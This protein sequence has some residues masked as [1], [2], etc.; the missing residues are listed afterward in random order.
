MASPIA[1]SLAGLSIYW[2]AN[3]QSP[4]RSVG[5]I[6]RKTI[7]GAAGAVILA[8]LSDFDLIAGWIVRKYLHHQF[9][10]TLAFAVLAGAICALASPLFKASAR[11][12]FWLA[13]ALVAS[14]V[15]IDYFTKDTTTPKG[16]MVFWPITSRYFISP[17]SVFLDIWRMSPALAFG[18]NNFNA[19]LR[20]LAMGGFCLML[21]HPFH[22]LPKPLFKLTMIITICVSLIA[23]AANDVLSS[24][25]EQQLL[26]FW[27]PPPVQTTTTPSGNKGILF[28][29]AKA[30]N[31]DIY[32]VQPDGSNLR[33]LTTGL[34]ED[35]W[36]VWS[37]DGNW[38]VFQSDR[39]GNR[40]IWLMASDGSSQQNLTSNQ[41]MDESPFWTPSGNQIVFSSDRSGEFELYVMNRN[42]SN[43]KQITP[44]DKGMELL[45]AVSPVEEIVAYSANKPMLPGWHI[46]TMSLN[47]GKPMRVS[48]ES[49]CRAKWS[50]DGQYLAY[51]SG[52]SGSSTDI[53]T[54]RKDGRRR[55]PLLKSPEYEYDPCFSPDG[56]QICFAR[57]R[58][59]EKA[60]WDLWIVN[61]DGSGAKP[62]TTDGADNRFPCWR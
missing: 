60:G 36:P 21:V 24:R 55:L 45:P 46:Y 7:F 27:G 51:V 56:S 2:I 22:K 38:I 6:N 25:A 5:A 15:V 53:Y 58:G 42:G 28:A 26:E 31:M 12:T 47:G 14:H 52:F 37:P 13:T 54:F 4:V 41:A 50:P 32:C 16:C 18:Y 57:G 8:N 44:D 11:R 40:D 29:S 48:S 49:G 61:L 43:P 23:I 19:A 1:H 33:Q 10:H 17:I 30:G 62:L 3:R 39:T 20:E 9:S 34:A 35:I 59:T